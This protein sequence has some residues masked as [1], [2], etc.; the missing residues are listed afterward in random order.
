VFRLGFPVGIIGAVG[1]PSNPNHKG[2]ITMRKMLTAFALAALA[3]GPALASDETDVWA[4]VH[5]FEVGFNKGGD[6]KSALAACADQTSIID[7]IPPHEW[8]GAGACSKWL[9]DF[10]AFS[11]A[12]EITDAVATL[13]KPKHINITGDRAYVVAPATYTYKM[14][15]NPTKESGSILTV[16]LQKGPSGWRITGWSY[17]AG[18]EAAVKTEAA[19]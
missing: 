6:M 8:H 15:G 3:A 13:G 2:A 7:S 5:Q 9:S 10:N 4:V 16:A 18:I 19:K 14:K 11:K 17:T 12:N 1:V